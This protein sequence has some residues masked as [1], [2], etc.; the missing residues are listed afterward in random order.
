EG[1][2]SRLW[3]LPSAPLRATLPCLQG[4]VPGV[5]YVL[6]FSPDGKTL[7]TGVHQTARL[8]DVA[9]GQLKATLDGALAPLAFSPDGKTLAT[10]DYSPPYSAG[11]RNV[12]ET[13]PRLWDVASGQLKATLRGILELPYPH[14]FTPLPFSPHA[15]TLTTAT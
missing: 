8:W 6:A 13:T 3:G 2:T 10:G 4:G 14:A 9:S 12:G 11:P 7:A 5:L 1:P 15:Q